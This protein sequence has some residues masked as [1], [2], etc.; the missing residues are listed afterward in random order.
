MDQQAS[1]NSPYL[2]KVL[3]QLEKTK[4]VDFCIRMSSPALWNCSIHLDVNSAKLLM[5]TRCISW[6][7]KQSK[8]YVYNHKNIHYVLKVLNHAFFCE[9]W[10][11]IICQPILELLLNFLSHSPLQVLYN[12]FRKT[13]NKNIVSKFHILK[14]MV[15]LGHLPNIASTTGK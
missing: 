3:L 6:N 10:F 4:T 15:A 5:A 13:W 8:I 14:C 1:K 11:H 2:S 7:N 9:F 12:N